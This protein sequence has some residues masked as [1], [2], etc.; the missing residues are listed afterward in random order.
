MTNQFKL[1][2]VTNLDHVQFPTKLHSSR[3]RLL[4]RVSDHAIEDNKMRFEPNGAYVF[5]SCKQL[6]G[7]WQ[8][9][10]RKATG[11]SKWNDGVN[12]KL[13]LYKVLTGSQEDPGGTMP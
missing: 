7:C 11:G 10:S 12:E 9:H 4:A 6:I 5:M 3:V 1:L 2:D 8:D 13:Q